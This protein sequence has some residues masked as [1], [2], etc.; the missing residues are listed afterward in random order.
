MQDTSL[1][2]QEKS[3]LDGYECLCKDITMGFSMGCSAIGCSPRPFKAPSEW[4]LQCLHRFEQVPASLANYWAAVHS[5]WWGHL[6]KWSCG[7]GKHPSQYSCAAVDTSIPFFMK[8]QTLFKLQ[9]S[10]LRFVKT[11]MLLLILS[12]DPQLENYKPFM[13]GRIFGQNN[14]CYFPCSFSLI[15]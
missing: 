14:G 12:S 2:H 5:T 15:P 4:Q 11:H 3:R 1:G 7:G 9:E 10:G 6:A 13:F 8:V